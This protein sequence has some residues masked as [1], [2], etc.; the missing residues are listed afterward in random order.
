MT[1]S[2]TDDGSK[3]GQM[4]SKTKPA[5]F[6]CMLSPSA[7]A[8]IRFIRL[9][10]EGR[11][12]D[13][14][15][16]DADFNSLR[17]IIMVYRGSL[18]NDLVKR[19]KDVIVLGGIK[20][21]TQR[22]VMSL[23]TQ[24]W[25]DN[26]SKITKTEVPFL[27]AVLKNPDASLKVL[28]EKARQ[29][30]AQ[31]RR[32]QRRLSDSGILKIGGMLNADQF[33]LERVL[34]VLES[35][36]LVLSGPYCQKALF[37]DGYSPMVLIVATVPYT[38]RK[39]LL[40]TVRSL[41]NSTTNATVYG[42]STGHPSFSGM[43][44]NPQKGWNLD[45]LH[46]QLMLRKGGDPITLAHLPTPSTSKTAHFTYAD[47]Q[48]MDALIEGLDGTA[49]DIAMNT[50]LSLSTVF[51]KR[52]SLLTEGAIVPRARI[53]IPQLSD[54]I[55]VICSPEVGGNLTPGWQNL[56]LTYTS[57]ISNLEDKLDK[58]MLLISALPTGSG[59][60]VLDV[61]NDET[62]K[63]DDYSA[64]KV[65]A[66]IGGGTK[67]SSMYDRRQNTWA[68]D[69]SRHFDAVTYGVMRQEASPHNIPLDLA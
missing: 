68:W 22:D 14:F 24:L 55:I 37:V 61:L 9:F 31:T 43:Y 47:T 38:K 19:L 64:W 21:I 25:E 7:Q 60:S 42:I 32:A 12:L 4:M 41:R 28:S 17:R 50:G 33:G 66:G 67:V 2:D 51:R 36:S 29:S 3:E 39:D 59:T 16:E 30:Y 46:F 18:H 5:D 44:S 10:E 11:P 63:V 54:R 56:P 57:Q 27:E 69:V 34:I 1:Q 23:V 49:N 26:I 35:P 40:D 13:V 20:I 45:L 62:S 48:V 52:T 15:Q 58:K 53:N 8:I 6:D 65:A